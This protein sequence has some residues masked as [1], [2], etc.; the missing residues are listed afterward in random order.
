MKKT[1]VA[2]VLLG[3]LLCVTVGYFAVTYS[4]AVKSNDRN[5]GYLTCLEPRILTECLRGDRIEGN[6]VVTMDKTNLI[7]KLPPVCG[8]EIIYRGNRD[9]M[10]VAITIDDGWNADKRIFQLLKD[11]DIEWTAFLIGGCNLA[12]AHP[13]FVQEIVGAGGEICNHTWSH[14]SM[15][16]KDRTFVTGEISAAQEAITRVTHKIYPYVRFYGGICDAQA[17]T[18]AEEMGYWVVNWTIDSLDTRKGITTEQQ[19]NE[20][21][22]RLKP[23]A[24]ILFHFGGYNTLEVMATV[25]PEIQRQGYE[26]TSLSRVFEGTPYQ[27][28]SKE[29]AEDQDAEQNHMVNQSFLPESLAPAE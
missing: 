15:A 4:P 17:L 13:E 12:D 8:T 27:L 20:I 28:K 22:S 10:R 14:L 5:M 16:G 23:G 1:A 24:I 6:C 18:W 3:V 9:L 26:V 21:L 25:I 11:W 19:V 7:G 2:R 29:A